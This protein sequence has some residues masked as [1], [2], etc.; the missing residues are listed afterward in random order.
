MYSCCIQHFKFGVI[1]MSMMLNTAYAGGVTT[2]IVN[3]TELYD[4]APNGYSHAVIV[5]GGSRKSPTLPVRGRK[6]P[7]NTVSVI[8]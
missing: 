4:P 2:A 7:G 5:S 1:A 8:Y 3:P 6:C